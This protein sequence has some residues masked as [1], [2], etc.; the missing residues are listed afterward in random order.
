MYLTDFQ[1]TAQIIP[2]ITHNFTVQSNWS[3]HWI[4]STRLNLPRLT[5]SIC[6][7]NKFHLLT[8][9]HPQPSDM[10]ITKGWN[11]ERWS[12]RK[13]KGRFDFVHNY[14][15]SY[16]RNTLWGCRN[17]VELRIDRRGPPPKRPRLILKLVS[18]WLQREYRLVTLRHVNAKCYNAA[19]ALLRCSIILTPNKVLSD[20]RTQ[21]SVLI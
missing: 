14:Y 17:N 3:H 1:S 19:P 12:K 13:S 9:T 20:K 8:S 16:D 2:V 7:H 11:N 5:S 4:S 15:H 18:H 21:A 10:Q 6:L